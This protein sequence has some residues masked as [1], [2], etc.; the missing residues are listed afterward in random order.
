MAC[1]RPKDERVDFYKA[2][3]AHPAIIQEDSKIL[4][5]KLAK[6]RPENIPK[7][8]CQRS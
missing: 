8:V 7:T 1:F 6:K 5:K 3:K 4:T 2:E